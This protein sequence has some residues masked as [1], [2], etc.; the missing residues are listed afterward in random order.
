MSLLDFANAYRSD[1]KFD[2]V[3]AIVEAIGVPE[4]EKL[5]QN[6]DAVRKLLEAV[7]IGMCMS[8]QEFDAKKYFAEVVNVLYNLN[9]INDKNDQN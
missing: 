4:S 6:K 8:D 9:C 3:V 5:F 7:M 2:Q 1:T